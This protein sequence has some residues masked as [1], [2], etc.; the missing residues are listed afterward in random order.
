MSW[1]PEDAA[2]DHV[3]GEDLQMNWHDLLEFMTRRAPDF[4]P[5]LVGAS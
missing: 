5:R 1:L 2:A 4:G 3:P